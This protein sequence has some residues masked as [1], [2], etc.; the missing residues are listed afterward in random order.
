VRTIASHEVSSPGKQG[1]N[2][3]GSPFPEFGKDSCADF[4]LGDYFAYN[5]WTDNI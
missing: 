1:N 5:A 4:T 3:C 2:M